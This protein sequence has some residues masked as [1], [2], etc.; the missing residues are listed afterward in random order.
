MQIFYKYARTL[1][2][3]LVLKRPD[4]VTVNK[5]VIYIVVLTW[6]LHSVQNLVDGVNNKVASKNTIIS[7]QSYNI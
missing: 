4:H 1:Q 7:L 2:L 6:P 3:P 5:P